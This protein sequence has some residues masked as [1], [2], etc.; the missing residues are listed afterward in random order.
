[1][2]FKDLDVIKKC[3]KQKLSS[4]EGPVSEKQEIDSAYLSVVDVL[5][6]AKIQCSSS[7]LEF[8]EIEKLEL[9]F[10]I[11][12]EAAIIEKMNRDNLTLDF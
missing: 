11:N 10:A 8:S 4:F 12:L 1:M 3:L 7:G 6:K 5:S 9:S 2:T